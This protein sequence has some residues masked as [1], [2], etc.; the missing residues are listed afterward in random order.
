M[1]RRLPIKTALFPEE[2]GYFHQL[3][4]SDQHSCNV[5]RPADDGFDPDQGFA[6]VH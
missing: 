1:A 4:A 5:F 3:F 6:L 2:Q